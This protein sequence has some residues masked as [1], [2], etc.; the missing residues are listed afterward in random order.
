MDRL[1]F[2]EHRGA[3][4]CRD[5]PWAPGGDWR[6]WANT[7]D[8]RF[9]EWLQL[10]DVPLRPVTCADAAA[11]VG[12]DNRNHPIRNYFD[13]LRW[14]G[15][16]RLDSWLSTYLGVEPDA[17]GYVREVGRRWPISAVAGSIARAARPITR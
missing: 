3:V 10:R 8:L 17:A 6:E 14:D 15:V 11:T 4:M 12:D 9:A 7:D 2:D 13:C 16:R 1:A 5:L